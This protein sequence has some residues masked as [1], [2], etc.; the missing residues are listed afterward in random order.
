MVIFA[1]AFPTSPSC[2][3]AADTISDGE[4]P[5]DVCKELLRSADISPFAAYSIASGKSLRPLDARSEANDPRKCSS[6]NGTWN[7][8]WNYLRRFPSVRHPQ[9]LRP[10]MSHGSC[11]AYTPGPQPVKLAELRAKTDLQI[12]NIIHSKLELCLNLVA[13]VEDTYSVGSRDHAEQ[14]L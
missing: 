5:T 4:A 14:L 10:F 9:I 1:Q 2:K 12:V 11:T 8:I 13:L 3:H 7:R 6:R